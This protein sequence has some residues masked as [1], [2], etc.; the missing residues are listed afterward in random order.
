[1]KSRKSTLTA[2]SLHL[3]TLIAE[4]DL[5]I[6]SA[7]REMERF[8][9]SSETFCRNSAIVCVASFAISYLRRVKKMADET[10]YKTTENFIRFHKHQLEAKATDGTD[11]LHFAQNNVIMMFGKLIDLFFDK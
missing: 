8:E 7:L 10:D 4:Y 9:V 2:I 11:T 1:M 6:S 3:G 5:T